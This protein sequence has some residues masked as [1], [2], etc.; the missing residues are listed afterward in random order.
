MNEVQ[1]RKAL[2]LIKARGVLGAAVESARDG[3]T[4]A[5]VRAPDMALVYV[6]PAF[7]SMTGYKAEQV[8]GRNCRFLQRH[9]TD[10]PGVIELRHLISS[11]RAGIVTLRN[12]RANGE[13]FYN[14]LSL[15]PV[16]DENGEV[17]HFVGIQK[18]IT[19]RVLLQQRLQKRE[20]ELRELNRQ[21]EHIAR[22]DGLTG[23]YNRRSFDSCLQREWARALRHN[24][25]ISLFM[26]D[27]DN[28]KMLND[29]DGHQVGDQCLIEAGHMLEQCFGRADD[30]V[31]RYGGEEF[32]V[33]CTNLESAQAG[34]RAEALLQS[35]RNRNWHPAS[36]PVTLSIGL[37]TLQ[38]S[39]G[40]TAS[41]ALAAADS[42]LYRAKQEGRDR[43]VVANGK[44]Q[45]VCTE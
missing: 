42:A 34:A 39:A 29:T 38:P 7:L 28:F 14:E 1:S 45:P 24:T 23:L 3:I 32:V 27:L 5:D 36:K 25:P 22:R 30:F 26:I 6:N 35:C 17:T 33:L 21:L 2:E 15:S 11:G 31:A 40:M 37:C 8:L 44:L 4:V 20:L 9:E 18:E 19:E 13:L 16:L 10:Q 43:C 41:Q 12:Y